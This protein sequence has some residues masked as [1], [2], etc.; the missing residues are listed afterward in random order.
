M[1][2]FNLT[3]KAWVPVIMQNG[4]NILL[5]LNDVF[6]KSHEIR[7]I[8]SDSVLETISIYRFL[9]ALLI[10][11]YNVNEEDNWLS[12][13]E[14]GKFDA[15]PAKEY[16]TK[17]FARFD[18][19]DK[20]RPFYQSTQTLSPDNTAFFKLRHEN[21]S[22]NAATLF[23]HTYDAQEI[24]VPIWRIPALL[25]TAQSYSVGGGISKPFNFSGSPL[26]GGCTFWI[27]EEV[28]FKSLLLNTDSD[29]IHIRQDTIPS[30]ERDYCVKCISRVPEDYLDYLTW[31]SRSIKFVC[32]D[33]C[34][35]NNGN[36]IFSNQKAKMYF[37][38]GDRLDAE[39]EDPL[40]AKKAGKDKVL[41]VRFDK[42][43]ALWRNAEVL[44]KNEE[45]N[46]V[47]T[48][49]NLSFVKGEC[50]RL[51]YDLTHKF[52]IEA[53][54]LLN[55]QAKIIF[56][57]KE[58]L[59]FFPSLMQKEREH[60]IPAFLTL[61][62]EQSKI[63][64]FALF[65]LGRNILYSSKDENAKLSTDEKNDV[66]RFIKSLSIEKNYW[67]SLETLFLIYL[68]KAA[69]AEF[70]EDEFSDYQEYIKKEIFK[71]AKNAF[72]NSTKNFDTNAKNI[73]AITKA[74]QKLYPIN[75]K[76][77]TNG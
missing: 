1:A 76:E 33:E 61:A 47:R 40:M 36:M 9:Q 4:D 52:E 30:W 43:K 3:D 35:D 8:H 62:D 64:Y 12:I 42:E 71:T 25:I 77:N 15:A 7:E 29:N 14:E 20:D 45:I 23:D 73:R 10:R 66:N 50:Y 21:S 59:S 44:F 27:K 67:T 70:N 57:K 68:E 51:G 58:I 46:G 48:S 54:G 72:G 11:I 5:S 24:A 19:F 34:F 2:S 63:L 56:I 49:K 60:L 74:N 65:S 53:Y 37:H 22:A 6:S 41:S 13:W 18:I 16:F 75:K 39:F 32:D 31:Q 69:A 17:W 28:L 38:Q 55:D 26:I